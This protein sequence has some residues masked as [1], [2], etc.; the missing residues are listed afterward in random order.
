VVFAIQQLCQRKDESSA[1][2]TDIAG[3]ARRRNVGE[4]F[5]ASIVECTG[6]LLGDRHDEPFFTAE[7]VDQRILVP[8]TGRHEDLRRRHRIDA[9]LREHALGN[10]D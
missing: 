7:V 8:L 3:S 10:I 5:V 6:P 2:G 9:T 4:N 1:K